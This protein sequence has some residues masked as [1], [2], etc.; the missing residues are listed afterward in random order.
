MKRIVLRR[1]LG[2][3]WKSLSAGPR[4]FV[5][6]LVLIFFSLTPPVQAKYG[7]GTGE[8]NDPYLIYTAEQLNTIGLNRDDF[9][10]HFKLMV[11]VDLS[12]LGGS[13]FN[14]IGSYLH[15]YSKAPFTG[16]FD[17][18]GH[19]ISG[20]RHDG[21][22]RS[23]FGVFGYIEDPNAKVMDLGLSEPN[24]IITSG[25]GGAALVGNLRHGTIDGCWAVGASVSG[26]NS[27]G[28]LIAQ[29][30]DARI[31]DCNFQGQVTGIKIVGGLAGSLSSSDVSNCS[32]E[33]TVIGS[34]HV[35]GL[36]GSI[37]G[38]IDGCSS[39]GVVVAS[40]DDVGGLAGS[41][42]GYIRYCRASGSVDG[43]DN[44]GGL[45]GRSLGYIQACYAD[46]NCSGHRAIGGLVGKNTRAVSQCSS[47]GAV[48]GLYQVGGLIGVNEDD[49]VLACYAAGSVYGYKYVGGLIGDNVGGPSRSDVRYCYSRGRVSAHSRG[50]YIGGLVGRGYSSDTF[51]CFWDS[52]TSGQ[53]RSAGG[54]PL[55]TPQM[56]DPNNFID[57]GWDFVGENENGSSDDWAMEESPGYPVL[58]WQADPL[59]LLPDFS[60]G[61]GTQND[62]YLISDANELHAIGH[63]FRL[64]DACFKLVEDIDLIEVEFIPIGHRA[65]PFSGS[66][67]GNGR[68]ISGLT[69]DSGDRDHIGLFS[70]ISGGGAQIRNLT[71]IGP[72]FCGRDYVGSLAGYVNS[73]MI[74]DCVI[75]DANITGRDW[76]GGL[77]GYA[78]EATVADCAVVDANITGSEQVG[79]LAGYTGYSDV[80]N[81]S[82]TGQIYA[83]RY[84]GGL[85]GEYYWGTINGC[86]AETEILANTHIGGLVGYCNGSIFDCHT[87][88][89]IRP[90]DADRGSYVGGFLG[91]GGGRNINRCSSAGSIAGISRV[92]GFGGQ[93]SSG[94]IRECRSTVEVSGGASAGGF[95]GWIS[96]GEIRECCSTAAVSGD[97][98]VG[99]FAG[100]IGYA[101]IYNC[102][103][104]ANV[105]ANSS[106]GGFAGLL[107]SARIFNCYAVGRVPDVEFSGGFA[108]RA[109]PGDPV[110]VVINSFWDVDSSGLDRDAAVEGVTGLT[111]TQM[112]T[113]ATYG[114]WACED[115][116]K[117]DEGD[118]PSLIWEDK[119]GQIVIGP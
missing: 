29:A 106:A 66:F 18:N 38:T 39:F 115:A 21:P 70:Y 118:Y 107:N 85:T 2:E 108:G 67:D 37:S 98:K 6:S 97:T 11:D 94:E 31:V 57:A 22:A 32:F 113:A 30:Y 49:K 86:Y 44:V 35:G 24:V 110:T 47:A 9:D 119:P 8:P 46:A 51:R 71:L 42:G 91:Y 23:Y 90:R 64:M 56:Y 82:V 43:Y 79:G 100:E 34:G 117:I 54:T 55:T 114:I 92:G 84:V 20:L 58:W 60:G 62:P 26:P 48:T 99:G 13:G 77:L 15:Y 5:Y 16:V 65:I 25:Y 104:T 3:Q 1:V 78:Y 75:V 14:V 53:T 50:D 101:Y 80:N 89:R 105:A 103:S 19:I 83:D 52:D 72:A 59:P 40:G 10:K 88:C 45:V 76:V 4:L 63:N 69:C 61:S 102:Y 95:A 73:A 28:G 116:W 112:Q 41:A 87:V 33:G 12:E 36:A 74:A 27:V 109:E 7:G 68:S 96:D 93:I 17:G 111:T 81:C